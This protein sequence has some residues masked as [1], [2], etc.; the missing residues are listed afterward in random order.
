MKKKVKTLRPVHPN[1]GIQYDYRRRLNALIDEMH[2]DVIAEVTKVYRKNPPL[3]GQDE[4]PYAKLRNIMQEMTRKWQHR[5]GEVAPKLAR[6]FARAASARSAAAL[7]KILKDGGFT[8]EFGL[9][10]A[11]Q[12]ILGAAIHENVELIKSIAHEYLNTVEGAVMR[13]VQAGFDLGALTTELE[14]FLPHNKKRAAF[15]ARDQNLK[16]TGALNR[17]RQLDLGI[18][19]AIWVHSHGGKVPRPT[20][21]KAG[22]DKQRY[23]VQKGWYDPHEEQWI[24]PGQ[25]INCRCVS[26][27]IIPGLQ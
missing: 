21:V 27:S 6:Y 16:I 5:F 25:L 19:T 26:R 3:I 1:I 12:D 18:T 13:A 15:I 17:A 22:R 9:T 11:Q 10:R 23:D 24:Q 8:I 14:Q 2:A 7:K 20:H 4:L